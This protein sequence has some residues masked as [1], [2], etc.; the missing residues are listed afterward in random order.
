MTGG[1][2]GKIQLR[3]YSSLKEVGEV[4]AYGWKNGYLSFVYGSW[5]KGVIY[6][7]GKDGSFYMWRLNNAEIKGDDK[8]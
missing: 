8:L 5:N 4:K 3:D 7:A 2:E 6:T 1:K